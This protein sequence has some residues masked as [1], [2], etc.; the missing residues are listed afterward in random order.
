[1]GKC[2]LCGDTGVVDVQGRMTECECSLLRRLAASMPGHI[3]KSYVDPGHYR[4]P[5]TNSTDKSLYIFASWSDMKS[6]IKVVMYKHFGMFIRISSDREIRD[7]GVGS[8]SRAARGDNSEEM[9]YNTLQDLMSPPKLVIIRLNELA[10]KNKAAP[11]FLEEALSY[12]MDRDLP[13]WLISD[14]DKPFGQGCYAWSQSV[15]DMITTM[16]EKVDVPR[17]SKGPL[18]EPPKYQNPG[19]VDVTSPIY[20]EE[21]SKKTKAKT[22][23]ENPDEYDAMAAKFGGGVQKK[24]SK[25][26]GG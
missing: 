25:K 5:I 17:I 1:M 24:K 19:Y 21:K 22:E 18:I 15:W 13:T 4:H 2:S 3:R 7:V 14:R 6:L 8:T 10:Y 9:I 16:F 23:V 20:E 12:R 11:G 26:F